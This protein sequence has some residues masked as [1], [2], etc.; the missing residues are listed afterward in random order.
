MQAACPTACDAAHAQFAAARPRCPSALRP[1]LRAADRRCRRA[2][3]AGLRVFLAV[4]AAAAYFG[5]YHQ[6]LNLGWV[7]DNYVPLMSGAIAFSTALSIYLY[8]SS[9]AR[10]ALLAKGGNTGYALYDFFI[11]RE[12]N[13]RLGGFDL[14]EFCELYPGG[15]RAQRMQAGVRPGRR[16]QGRRG[17]GRCAAAAGRPAGPVSRQTCAA[18]MLDATRLPAQQYLYYSYTYLRVSPRRP[19]RLGADRSSHGVQ[20]VHPAGLCHACHAAGLRLPGTLWG[21]G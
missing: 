4:L 17:R 16:R 3:L 21:A 1:G 13:P 6:T 11:G 18:A 9:F 5:F 19:D 2:P 7:Y 14:K 20:A 15:Q 8:A 10:G 12:L